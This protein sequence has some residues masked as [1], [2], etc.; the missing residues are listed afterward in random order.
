MNGS[1][2]ISLTAPVRF[3]GRLRSRFVVETVSD[4]D[5]IGT[6]WE[7]ARTPFQ[8][9]IWLESWYGSFRDRPGLTP[10]LVTARD[11]ETGEVALRLPLVLQRQGR[12]RTISF[13]D[14]D[15]TDYNAPLLG[16][17]AP[18]DAVTMRALWREILRALPAADL[19]SLAK[20]P[21]L[22]GDL[23]NP[24]ALLAQAVPSAVNGNV[25]ETGD[26]WDLW[27]RSLDKTVR[28]ELERSWRVFE[29][30][31]GARFEI[32]TDPAEAQRCVTAMEVQQ[33]ARMHAIGADYTLDDPAAAAFYR[34]LVDDGLA[35]GYAI[36]TALVVGDAIVASLLGIRDERSYVMIRICN[37]GGDW[38][39]CSPGRL[40][41][42]RTMAALHAEGCRAFDFSIGNY[43]YK[44]RFNVASVPLV[45]VTAPLGWRGAAAA[46]RAAMAGRLRLH[47]ELDRRLRRF[48]GQFVKGR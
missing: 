42:E 41:I 9:P 28:K 10:L 3:A 37:A 16:S 43:D 1:G 30:H 17:A 18:S 48:A 32:V 4:W 33:A 27:R 20:M 26:D 23:P 44:R 24:L 21:A 29:R 45:N 46:L 40:V 31:D 47:P 19:I 36:V 34:R 14:L 12:M 2:S 35:S 15:L 8:D 5:A 22:L 25:V 7:G 39:N 13:A 6:R 11:R 38:T